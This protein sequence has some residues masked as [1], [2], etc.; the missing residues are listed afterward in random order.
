MHDEPTKLR[1][2]RIEACWSQ[3]Q[4]I[5]R[6]RLLAPTVTPK[7]RLPGDESMKT[8]MN[9]WENGRIDPGPDYQRLFRAVYNLTDD[10]LGFPAPRTDLVA[11]PPAFSREGLAYFESLFTQHVQAD[12][13]IGPHPIVELVKVQ[14][15][16]LNVAARDMRGPL[17]HDVIAAASRFLEFLGWLQQDSGRPNEAMAATDRARDLATELGNPLWNAYLLMRKSNIATD[18]NDPATAV[19][20]ADAALA[21][22]PGEPHRVRA[23]ILRQ[24]ANAHAAL[25]EPDDCAAA[26]DESLDDVDHEATEGDQV[27]SYCTTPYVAMEAADCWTRLGQPDRALDILRQVHAPWPND[28]R[29]DE[30][31]SLARAAAAKAAAGDVS[32]AETNGNQAVVVASVTR[33]ARTIRALQRLRTQLSIG[34]RQSPETR[35]L[36]SAIASLAGKAA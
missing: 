27:A 13:A 11:T 32:A 21:M 2:A 8:N 3:M 14:A 34:E 22:V 9:R 6:M 17:R 24:K 5:A 12:N 36:C 25:G 19:A 31:L 35:A 15:H 23:V 29:R 16:Q 18:A 26:I 33:S 4:V 1:R 7:F 10:E 30:G 28:L 20:L